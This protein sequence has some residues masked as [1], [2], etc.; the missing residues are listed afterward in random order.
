[1]Q[2]DIVDRDSPER[3]A[4]MRLLSEPIVVVSRSLMLLLRPWKRQ[5]KKGAKNVMSATAQMGTMYFFVDWV[6]IQGI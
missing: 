2:Y 3:P 6:G 5:K 4:V 1:M